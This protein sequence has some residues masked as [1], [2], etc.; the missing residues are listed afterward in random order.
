MDKALPTDVLDY[1]LGSIPDLYTLSSAVQVSK[2]LHTVYTARQRSLRAAVARNEAG[3]ALPAALRLARYQTD[4]KMNWQDFNWQ[5]LTED[6]EYDIDWVMAPELRANAA[7]MCELENFYS[8]VF[9]DRTCRVSQLTVSE[10]RKLSRALYRLA[11]YFE[12]WSYDWENHLDERDWGSDDEDE[13]QTDEMREW[14]ETAASMREDQAI[15]L[16]STASTDDE[17]RELCAAFIFLRD[18]VNPWAQTS[19]STSYAT[20]AA[21]IVQMSDMRAL[22]RVLARREHHSTPGSML[23]WENPE[24]TRELLRPF[25]LGLGLDLATVDPALLL[26][27]HPLNDK[28]TQCGNLS[29][30]KLFNESNWYLLYGY[31]PLRD[32]CIL[33]FKSNLMRNMAEGP[34]IK[35]YFN[36]TSFSLPAFLRELFDSAAARG[37]TSADKNAWFCMDCVKNIIE[38]EKITWWLDR[39]R[40]DGKTIPD[41]C[42]YGYECRTQTHKLDHAGK[43]NHFCRPTRG[44]PST[45]MSHTGNP[46]TPP[47]PPSTTAPASP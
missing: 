28:C 6:S 16:K 23:P 41:D 34:T 43:L 3:P 36:S 32:I 44:A 46:Q 8:Q 22:A 35:A 18:N 31:V 7:A 24:V 33:G 30:Q 39:K 9:K 12:R 29:G 42:W 10:S 1:I 15:F 25:T 19:F 21:P 47:P 37:V 20:Y 14:A 5:G 45:S 26:D 27:E 4:K 38:S 13:E 17:R 40:A 11:L 2:R